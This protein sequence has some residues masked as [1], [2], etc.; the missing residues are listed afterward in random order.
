MPVLAAPAEAFAVL[1]WLS[2][3]WNR[4]RGQPNEEGWEAV[5][6]EGDEPIEM[7]ESRTHR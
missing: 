5:A 2:S 6:T 3:S 4:I 1:E 7:A